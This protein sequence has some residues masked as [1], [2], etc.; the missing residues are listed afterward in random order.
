MYLVIIKLNIY[1]LIIMHQSLFFFNFF[2]FLNFF[3]D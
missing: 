1:F 2:N 3:F